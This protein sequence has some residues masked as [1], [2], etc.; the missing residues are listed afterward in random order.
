MYRVL[1]VC[2]LQEDCLI[3]EEL[4]PLMY[5]HHPVPVDQNKR[6]LV[7]CVIGI[8][9]YVGKERDFIFAVSDMLGAQ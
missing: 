6:P 8:S 4:V 3:Q 2:V 9:S 5:Y 7:D 1:C